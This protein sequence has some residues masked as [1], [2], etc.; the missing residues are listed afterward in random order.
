[1]ELTVGLIGRH[2]WSV[3]WAALCIWCYQTVDQPTP[4]TYT[5]GLC[6]ELSQTPY[7][8]KFIPKSIV[9]DA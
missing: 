5:P 7:T 6:A 2:L 9:Y 1:M 8:Y 4:I 3:L